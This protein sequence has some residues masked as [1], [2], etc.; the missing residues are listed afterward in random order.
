[1]ANELIKNVATPVDDE[2][3]VNKAYVDQDT[4]PDPTN[5]FQTITAS[6][7]GD[8]MYLTD[9]NYLIVPG[10][11]DANYIK[12][13]DGNVYNEVEIGNQVWL[14]ENLSTTHYNDGTPIP[15]LTDNADWDNWGASWN[16][17]E[18]TDVYDAYSWYNNDSTTYSKFGALYNWGVVDSTINGGKNACPV[19]YIIPTG[20]DFQELIVE[21]GGNLAGLYIK[22]APGEW[23]NS[24]QNFPFG[25]KGN[26]SSNYSAVGSENR[27]NIGT[28]S[29]NKE[30]NLIY[31]RTG[32]VNNNV[33]AIRIH[34]NDWEVDF[35][36]NRSGNDGYSL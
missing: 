30:N 12:D 15:N 9:G 25:G 14:K 36:T 21:I 5:E 27:N 35:Y 26:N 22:Y 18:Y 20:S 13:F 29:V 34:Y 4:D 19:G 7:E 23:W 28:F 3:A 32:G 2:D 33:N 16:G 8:T 10:I 17:T 1:M 31:A 24:A 6:V 11:S